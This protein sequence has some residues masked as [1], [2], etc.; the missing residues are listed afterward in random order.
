MKNKIGIIGCGYVGLIFGLFLAREQSV[1]FFDNNK[2]RIKEFNAG[3]FSAIYEPG[4][5]T[6]LK[7]NNFSFVDNINDLKSCDIIFICVGTPNR[8]DGSLNTDFIDDV[9]SN[10]NNLYFEDTCEVIIRSIMPVGSSAKLF[11]KYINNKIEYGL[12]PEFLR[13]GN[14]FSDLDNQNLVV[15]APYKAR[16]AK[17]KALYEKYENIKLVSIETAELIKSANNSWHATKIVFANEMDKIC[18]KVGG[19]SAE[20]ME[21]FMS[22]KKLNISTSYLRPGNPFGGSCLVKDTTDLASSYRSEFFQSIMDTNQTHIDDIVKKCMNYN[23]IGVEGIS[24]KRGTNDLRF[25]V[26]LYVAEKLVDNGKEVLVWDPIIKNGNFSFKIVDKDDLKLC[27]Y[28]FKA[29]D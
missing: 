17:T 4:L 19:D 2:K 7:S 29:H 28:I 15:L 11:D 22:D 3:D 26:G 16:L 18:K 5:S 13:E 1:I 24:F 9:L 6:Y 27:D 20:L 23:L 21:V 25:S 10:I 12:N 14:A 8:K